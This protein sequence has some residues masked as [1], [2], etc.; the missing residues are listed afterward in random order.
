MSRT[1]TAHPPGTPAAKAGRRAKP[2]TRIA[3]VGVGKLDPQARPR[4]PRPPAGLGDRGKRFWRAAWA[5][6]I[7]ALWTPAMVLD[8]EA[9]AA[10]HDTS[11]GADNAEVRARLA[12][13]DSLGLTLRGRSMLGVDIRPPVAP[14]PATEAPAA[15]FDPA[16]RERLEAVG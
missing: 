3:R 12:L 13:E 14:E 8:L 7:A 9:V 2:D 1:A 10:L 5:D 16:R 15:G 6:P 4:V 11:I